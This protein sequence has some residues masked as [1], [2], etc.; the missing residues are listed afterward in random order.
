LGCATYDHKIVDNIY[1]YASFGAK[2]LRM[3]N[4]VTS[5]CFSDHTFSKSLVDEAGEASAVSNGLSGGTRQPYFEAQWDFASTVPGTEQAGLSVVASPDRG[6]GA[7]M[8]WVQMRDEPGG[9][10]IGFYDY[11]TGTGFAPAATTIATGLD[12]TRSHTIKITMQFVDGPSN[13]VVK[14]YVN[15]TLVH[16]GSSWEDYFREAESNP[17][18]PVDSIL[19][20]T[21]GTAAPATAGNGFLIDNLMLFSGPVPPPP[22]PCTT[23]CYVDAVNGSD[24]NTGTSA[25][26]PSRPSRKAST[27]CSRTGRLSWH[28]AP[29]SSR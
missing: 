1:G 29:I 16:T 19:F 9:L 22:P 15:G 26:R 17:T 5:G 28:K 4:A 7:R 8:S 27:R 10:A 13:D 18:R 20:R 6:D 2:S 24:S 23:T 25:Q 21:G 11:I 3:S 14:V 12:R